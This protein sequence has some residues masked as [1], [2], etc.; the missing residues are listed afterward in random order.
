MII[1][2]IRKVEICGDHR[3]HGADPGEMRVKTEHG[4]LIAMQAEYFR[5][6]VA[7]QGLKIMN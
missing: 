4:G 2:F 5:T 3:A 1:S 6:V 7:I